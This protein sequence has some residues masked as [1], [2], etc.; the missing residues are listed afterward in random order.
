MIW[1]SC[2]AL[3]N[4]LLEVDGLSAKWNEGVRSDWEDIYHSDKIPT[5]VNKMN[6]PSSIR[7]FD[8][9]RSGYG[10]DY[11][12]SNDEIMVDHD[13]EEEPTLPIPQNDNE[14]FN[15]CDLSLIQICNRLITHFNI[16]L[17]ER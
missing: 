2:C 14:S 16:L 10:N 11:E 7:N 8:L 17:L 12:L 3:H 13:D 1:L 6:N 4:V 9:S 15:V 5:A